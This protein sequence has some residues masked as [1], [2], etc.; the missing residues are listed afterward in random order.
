MS[1]CSKGKDNIV[2]T[3]REMQKVSKAFIKK[4]CHTSNKIDD[5]NRVEQEERE[6]E[7]LDNNNNDDKQNEPRIAKRERERIDNLNNND[8]WKVGDVEDME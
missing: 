1:S 8:E 2:K 7:K 6:L 3:E 4:I 5:E